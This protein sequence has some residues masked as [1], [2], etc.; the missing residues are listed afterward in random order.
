MSQKSEEKDIAAQAQFLEAIA[1]GVPPV[2]AGIEV[3]WSPAETKRRLKDHE[4]SELVRVHLDMSIDS[5]ERALHRLAVSGHLGAM[6]M[7]LYNR[8]PQDW[9]DV[10]RIEVKTQSSVQVAVVTATAKQIAL[11]LLKQGGAAAVQPGGVLDVSSL[12]I[13]T[14]D[15]VDHS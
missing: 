1:D 3:G 12:E 9:K 4:F 6:Q 11:E 10:R 8:R 15:G 5:V 7:I 2:L 14:G 13:G